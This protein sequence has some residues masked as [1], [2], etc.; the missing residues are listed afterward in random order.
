MSSSEHEHVGDNEP[1][2][3]QHDEIRTEAVW[4]QSTVLDL[5]DIPAVPPPPFHCFF[6]NI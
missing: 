5:I 6:V 1:S 2:M 3:A 4:N